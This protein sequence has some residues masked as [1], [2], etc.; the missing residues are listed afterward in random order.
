MNILKFYAPWCGQ[1]KVLA[2]EFE[3]HRI[4]VPV[5]NINADDEEDLVDKYN[6]RSLP[7]TIL[8][9]DNKEIHRWHGFITVEE[10]NKKIDDCK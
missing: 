6:V 1:C 8:I 3:K 9:K 5:T 7:T 2:Q 10:I 4:N